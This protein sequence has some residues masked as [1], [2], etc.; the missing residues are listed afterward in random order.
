[1]RFF[2]SAFFWFSLV[3]SL[4]VLAQNAPSVVPLAVKTPYLNAWVNSTLQGW[5]M[6]WDMK[7]ENILGWIGLARVDG[8][9]YQWMGGFPDIPHPKLTNTVLTPTRTILTFEAGPNVILNVTYLSPIETSDLSLQSLPFSYMAVDVISKDGAPHDVQLYSDVSGEWASSSNTDTAQWSTQFT[10]DSIIQKISTSTQRSFV[11]TNDMVDD[12]IFYYAMPAKT[13][14]LTW[15]TGPDTILRPGFNATGRLNGTDDREFRAV[16]DHWPVLAISVDLGNIVN[17]TSPVVWSLGLVREPVVQ[18]T[19]APGKM[20]QRSAFYQSKFSSIEAAI[21]TFIARFPDALKNAVAFDNSLLSRAA[22]ISQDYADL[23]SLTTRTAL[24]STEMTV[25][26]RQ[27]GT[28]T[29]DSKDIKFFMRDTG[30][31]PASASQGVRANPVDAMFASWPLWMEMNPEWGKH[32]LEPLFQVQRGLNDGA[33]GDL[34]QA[35]PK[36]SKPDLV[37]SAQRAYIVE[38]SASMII[39]A[40]AHAQASGD[41]S[42]LSSEYDTLHRWATRSTDSKSIPSQGSQDSPNLVLKAILAVKAMSVISHTAGRDKDAQEFSSKSTSMLNQWMTTSAGADQMFYPLF[43]DKWL[44]LGLIS[45]EIYQQQENRVKQDSSPFGVP[46]SAQSQGMVRTDWTM[47]TA[48]LL[49]DTTVRDNWL[50]KV[51]KAAKL[52]SNPSSFGNIFSATSG[53]PNV[54]GQASPALG[55]TFALLRSTVPPKTFSVAAPKYVNVPAIVGGVLGG[56]L[57]LALLLF[58]LFLFRRR[59]QRRAQLAVLPVAPASRHSFISHAFEAAPPSDGAST[60]VSTSTD[61]T[62]ISFFS[63]KRRAP[64]PVGTSGVI[65]P[66]NISVQRNLDAEDPPPKYAP[67][68]GEHQV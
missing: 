48:S 56:V 33:V 64:T 49:Q 31:A 12:G 66:A 58:V 63:E 68:S 47:F 10:P 43:V 36:V 60:I 62:A 53:E 15:Q 2:F 19:T 27:D 59:Q 18:F 40:L 16:S 55:A 25:L 13:P 39:M 34:G 9:T 54:Q 5:P 28:G 6:F 26:K 8:V 57:F 22:T 41:G 51:N 46:L 61:T 21:S 38:S 42:L 65:Y 67:M 14:G 1:M 11:E 45:S 37:G 29:Y 52:S 24:S 20:E 23:I 44:G 3:P 17:S 35:F 7:S 4:L 30:A 50:N 32:L